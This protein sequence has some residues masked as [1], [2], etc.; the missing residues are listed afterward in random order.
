MHKAEPPMSFTHERHENYAVEECVDA[1]GDAL[2]ALDP[3]P[4]TMIAV[5]LR[6]HLEALL[7]TLLEAQ[8]CTHAEVRA[9][10]RELEREVLQYE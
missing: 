9:Y 6:V 3:Y 8:I 1:I 4:P 7:Q 5:A 10:L 2:R